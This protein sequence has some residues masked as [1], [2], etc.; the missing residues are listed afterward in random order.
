MSKLPDKPSEL[1]RVALADLE[2]C[3]ADPRYL[4]D[5]DRW[6]SGIRHDSNEPCAVCFAGSV[7]A[8]RL[9][10]D[11]RYYI[12]GPGR[13]DEDEGKLH[14]L[15][16]FREGR[17]AAG[18]IAFY[19]HLPSSQPPGASDVVESLVDEGI[20]PYAWDPSEFKSDMEALAEA[21]SERGM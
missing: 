4:I 18:L 15:N 6:H 12:S 5:M 17:I 14:A 11:H 20:S 1:I 7:M 9:G 2:K 8:Q 19:G 3:E 10:A 13:F 16:A 21:F